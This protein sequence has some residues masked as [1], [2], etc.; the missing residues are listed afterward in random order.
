MFFITFFN[1]FVWICKFLIE[2]LCHLVQCKLLFS[3][4]DVELEEFRNVRLFSL[5]SQKVLYTKSNTKPE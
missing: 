5:V 1:A 4:F 3:W 2:S